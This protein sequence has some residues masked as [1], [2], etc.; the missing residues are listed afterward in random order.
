MI[1]DGAAGGDR[2]RA[3]GGWKPPALPLSYGRII[4]HHDRLERAAGFE[5]ATFYLASRRSSTEL[6]PHLVE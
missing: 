5:P 4:T 1:S 3:V 6:R 2:T